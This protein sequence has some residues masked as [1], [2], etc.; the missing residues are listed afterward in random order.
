[1]HF[2][3][4]PSVMCSYAPRITDPTE[5]RSRLARGEGV[6]RE[7][8]HLA[9]ASP[10]TAVD[11][12]DAVGDGHDRPLVRTSDASERFWILLRIQIAD[13]RWFSC[14]IVAPS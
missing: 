7:L 13:F 14:C 10:P 9:L 5:S 1:V 4:P 11:A 12:A 3:C 8:Q 6:L 2:T